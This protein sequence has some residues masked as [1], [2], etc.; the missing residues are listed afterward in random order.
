MAEMGR[1]EL[2]LKEEQINHIKIMCIFC[3][4]VGNSHQPI[5][6]EHDDVINE[7]AKLTG[8]KLQQV[9]KCWIV[10][11]CSLNFQRKITFWYSP[12]LIQ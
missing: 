5:T 4:Y 1:D 6:V 8:I 7:L 9:I 12:I 3:R 2:A 10:E 11:M